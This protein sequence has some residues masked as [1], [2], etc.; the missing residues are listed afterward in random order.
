MG[1]L[2][3]SSIVD[4]LVGIFSLLIISYYYLTS[5]YNYWRDR[6][7]PFVKPI[8]LFGNIKDVL[9]GRKSIIEVHTRLY[10]QF[11]GERFGG[12]F[13]LRR[14][15]LMVRDPELIERLLV[16]DFAHF[17]DRGMTTDPDHEPLTLNLFNAKGNQWRNLRYKLTPTFTSGKLKGMFEQ[18]HNCGEDLMKELQKYAESGENVEAKNL[19]SL[20]TTDVI[21]S[22]AFGLQLRGGSSE[23]DTFKNMTNKIFAPSIMQTL[24]FN[25]RSLY[26]RLTKWF[27]ITTFGRDVN[28]YFLNITKAT[29]QLHENK[30]TKRNDFVQLLMN[31]KDQEQLGKAVSVTSEIFEEDK[32]ISQ[33]EYTSPETDTNQLNNEKCKLLIYYYCIQSYYVK[34]CSN[35]AW[36][37]MQ[38]L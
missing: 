3:D 15:V 5:T 25:L 31:L 11:E 37:K 4:V 29:I 34:Y 9:L 14:P 24:R 26:P 10:K 17:H 18:I 16:K 12:Y 23:A 6:G 21:A 7:I 30:G 32:V 2:S 27:G 38:L 19:F 28:E 13:V 36:T 8:L 22:C 33:S 35:F 1:I 20:F